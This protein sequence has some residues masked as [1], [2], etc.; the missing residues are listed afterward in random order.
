VQRTYGRLRNF[1]DDKY[2]GFLIGDDG[3]TY[4]VH[5]N[6]LAKSGINVP[7]QAGSRFSF[8]AEKTEKGFRA[9]NV[10]LEAA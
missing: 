9:A 3:E 10:E 5:G 8:D 4:F 1:V 7:P 6:E 2:F